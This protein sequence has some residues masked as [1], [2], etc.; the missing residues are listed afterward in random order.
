MQRLRGL[1][2]ILDWQRSAQMRNPVRF[3]FFSMIAMLP[4]YVIGACISSL[5]LLA[6]TACS[7]PDTNRPL[8]AV[9]SKFATPI[10]IRISGS[11][12]MAPMI[13]RLAER[14]VALHPGIGIEVL[15][16]P[17][18]QG[19]EDLRSG[20]VLIAMVAG[21]LGNSERDLQRLSIARDGEALMVAQ[22][23]PVSSI[24]RQ[25]LFGL[26]SGAVRNWSQLGGENGP[27]RLVAQATGKRERYAYEMYLHGDLQDRKKLSTVPSAAEALKLIRSDATVV[28]MVDLS[29]AQRLAADDGSVKL[30]DVDGYRVSFENL[31]RG[32]YP[33]LQ[34]MMLVTRD[35]PTGEV[36]DFLDFCMSS[37]A[38]DIARTDGFT[39]YMD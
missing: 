7:N 5:A 36:K 33:L 29:D 39:P 10:R 20:A 4:Q 18:R 32:L 26:F 30:L 15:P 12:E 14:Y 17:G 34:P 8:V 19:I 23:N 6:L 16:V 35:L 13:R 24:S 38:S 11:P 21:E 22:Q 2:A 3:S 31:R 27:I 1:F 25:G 28:A 37:Q 9:D